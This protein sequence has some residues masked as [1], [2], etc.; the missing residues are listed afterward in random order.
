MCLRL[1]FIV[2]LIVQATGVARVSK[3]LFFAAN[4]ISHGRDRKPGLLGVSVFQMTVSDQLMN[5]LIRKPS[6][7]G[8]NAFYPTLD[9]WPESV[10]MSLRAS[11]LVASVSLRG[12]DPYGL[13]PSQDEHH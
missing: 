2:G 5:V 9:S 7:H 13:F 1:F 10:Q 4:V 8:G 12:S 6:E 11:V 3:C